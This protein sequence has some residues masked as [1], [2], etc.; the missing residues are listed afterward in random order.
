[1]SHI[2]SAHHRS[3]CTSAV[4]TITSPQ[5][6]PALAQVDDL[7]RILRAAGRVGRARRVE[8]MHAGV[9][10]LL[11]MSALVEHLNGKLSSIPQAKS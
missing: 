4:I 5:S 3:V 1:V 10:H 6:P 11:E 8:I 9:Q 7:R 2:P